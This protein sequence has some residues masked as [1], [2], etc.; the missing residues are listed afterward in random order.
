M[1]I[2]P[3]PSQKKKVNESKKESKMLESLNIDSDHDQRRRV[4]EEEVHFL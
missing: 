4:R 3:L 1:Y 2:I